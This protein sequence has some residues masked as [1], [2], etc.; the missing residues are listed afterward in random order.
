MNKKMVAALDIG[1]SKIF[2]ITGTISGNN[3]EVTGAKVV[4]LPIEVLGNG[5]VKEPEILNNC[6]TKLLKSLEEQTGEKIKQVTLGIGYGFL[7]GRQYYGMKKIGLKGKKIKP[8]DIQAI[9]K[10]IKSQIH[11]DIAKGRRIFNEVFYYHMADADTVSEESLVGMPAQVLKTVAHVL[12]EVTDSQNEIIQ[13][14]ENSGVKVDKIFPH[15]WA[16]AEATLAKEENRNG[17]LFIDFG[18]RTADFALFSGNNAI[19][20]E[21]LRFGGENFSLD[22]ALALYISRE[23]AE[24]LKRKYAYLNYGNLLKKKH[25][26]LNRK[27]EIDDCTG[28]N[29]KRVTVK[30]ISKI[31]SERGTEIFEDFMKN[32]PHLN[33]LLPACANKIIITGGASRMKG[34]LEFSEEVFGLPVHIGIPLRIPGL[35]KKILKPEFSSGIGLLLLSVKAKEKKEIFAYEKAKEIGMGKIQCCWDG[36]T[37]KGLLGMRIKGGIYCRKHYN[38]LI[39]KKFIRQF[40]NF[41]NKKSPSLEFWD[42]FIAYMRTCYEEGLTLPFKLSEI[43]LDMMKR[44]KDIIEFKVLKSK[45]IG[46]AFEMW[47][48]NIKEK[49]L[50]CL[51]RT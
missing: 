20:T 37:H 23:S 9:K 42:D 41:N 8:S 45:D 30:R 15:S 29:K 21:S 28:K 17:C 11:S 12:F 25:P 38:V 31:A 32:S 6:L 18:K 1:S 13:A 51:D 27:I 39:E 35:D 22:I 44:N 48:F 33:S 19:T 5:K 49:K 14:V 2:G 46:N 10:Q 26:V 7:E 47:A 24:K 43:S 36:C 34:L 4:S 40:K 50:E 16:V 3:L